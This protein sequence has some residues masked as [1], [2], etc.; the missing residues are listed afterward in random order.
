MT[1]PTAP[2]S[3]GLPIS[4]GGTYDFPSFMRPRI[5]GSTDIKRLRTST[6][7]SFSGSEAAHAKV[8]LAVVGIPV[9]RDARQISRLV[10]FDIDNLVLHA[11]ITVRTRT[12]RAL[13]F[14]A[15]RTPGCQSD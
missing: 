9:G 15:L 2:P 14:R 6:S 10:S 13:D 12:S 3:S 7:W 4:K 5:Y 11:P 8:K 1:S